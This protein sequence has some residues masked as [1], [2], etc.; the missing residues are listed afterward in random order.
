MTT[1]IQVTDNLSYKDAEQQLLV[2]M[3]EAE[4]GEEMRR[5]YNYLRECDELLSDISTIL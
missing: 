1:I 2:L 4:R 5:L 3:D